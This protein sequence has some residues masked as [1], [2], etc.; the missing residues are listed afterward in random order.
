MR[1]AMAVVSQVVM[2]LYE[3]PGESWARPPTMAVASCFGS[4]QGS[5]WQVN[6]MQCTGLLCF[7]DQKITQAACGITKTM[8]YLWALTWKVVTLQDGVPTQCEG[9]VLSADLASNLL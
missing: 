2:L 6:A 3:A 4:L 7:F 5:H 9:V 8:H 1:L